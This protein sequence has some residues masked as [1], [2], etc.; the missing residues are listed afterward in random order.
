MPI[1]AYRCGSCNETHEALQKVSDDPLTTCP[2]C[3][4]DALKKIIAPVG[5]LFKG[6]G[7]HVNDYNGRSSNGNGNGKSK[8]NGTSSDSSSSSSSSESS[9]KPESKSGGCGGG[10][11]CH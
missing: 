7:F 1:Y 4:E 11:A 9:S 10:C 5:I 6:T 2:H 3:D 8:S